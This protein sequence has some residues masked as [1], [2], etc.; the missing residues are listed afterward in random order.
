MSL[1]PIA[2]TVCTVCCASLSVGCAPESTVSAPRV[3]VPVLLGP[4]DRIG[5]HPGGSDADDQPSTQF[6]VEVEDF[7]GVSR[8]QKQTGNLVITRTTTTKLH[9]GA[10]KVSAAVLG[11]TDAQHD[12]DVHVRRLRAGAWVWI[13][14]DCA[15]MMRDAWIDLDA[16]ATAMATKGQTR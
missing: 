16:T 13:T 15:S 3:P 7:A 1:Y 10:A 12:H 4:V 14:P 6:S 9:D 8:D 2:L 5:G 11:V